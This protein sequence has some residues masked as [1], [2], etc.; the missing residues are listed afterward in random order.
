MFAI[1]VAL[2]A[3]PPELINHLVMHTVKK[4]EARVVGGSDLCAQLKGG[5]SFNLCEFRAREMFVK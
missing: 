2:F 5:I 3:Y 4:R 1:A